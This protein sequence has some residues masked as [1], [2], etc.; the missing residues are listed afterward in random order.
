MNKTN[1]DLSIIILTMNA[2]NHIENCLTSLA[3][4]S[5]DL[6]IEIIISDNYS[7]DGT[8]EFVKENFTDIIFIQGDNRGYGAG[9]N[10]GIK[11]AKGRYLLILNDDTVIL[12]NGLEKM[13][14][15]MDANKDVGLLGPKLLNEDKS[16]QPSITNYPAIWK[17]IARILLPRVLQSNTKFMRRILNLVSSIIPKRKLGRYDLHNEI[18][19]VDAVKGACLFTSR[20]VID[21]VGGFDEDYFMHTEELDWA[22]RIRKAGFR[23]VYYPDAEI[24]HLGGGD[25][26]KERFGNS[27]QAV[28]AK[29]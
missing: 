26:W 25:I 9:N 1:T 23:V 19:D 27:R 21:K 14:R 2:I 8:A 29:A 13:V 6:K 7:T 28:F 12:D 24:T 4:N 15:F 3:E 10:R 11:I 22:Y 16:L 18:K 17:D 20:E 5:A